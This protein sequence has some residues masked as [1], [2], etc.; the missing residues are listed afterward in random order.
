MTRSNDPVADALDRRTGE[1]DTARRWAVGLEQ[2]CAYLRE[3]IAAALAVAEQLGCTCEFIPDNADPCDYCTLRE[4]LTLPA[5]GL[6]LDVIYDRA[7][8]G[9]TA[10]AV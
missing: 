8:A 2:E 9:A 1:R 3:Q 5:D 7:S 4:F 6:T 10:W